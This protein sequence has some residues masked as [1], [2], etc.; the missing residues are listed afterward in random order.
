MNIDKMSQSM[1]KYVMPIAEKFGN[2]RHLQA[3]RDAFMSL[4]PITFTG[5]IAAVLNSAPSVETAG[6]SLTMAWERG[7]LE[8]YPFPTQFPHPCRMCLPPSCRGRY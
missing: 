4:L 3:I 1:E 2:E 5:G 7:N 6:S 8:K